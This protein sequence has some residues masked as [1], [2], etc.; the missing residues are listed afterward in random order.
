M[1][2]S[3]MPI[4][5]M[6]FFKS[7]RAVLLLLLVSQSVV[8]VDPYPVASQYCMLACQISLN[9]QLFVGNGKSSDIQRCGNT[10]CIESVALCAAKYCTPSE[11][12]TGSSFLDIV[13]EDSGEE[14]PLVA[15]VVTSLTPDQTVAPKILKAGAKKGT[16]NTT[17][18]PDGELFSLALETA[19]RRHA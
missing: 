16:Q 3:G 6:A 5:S 10:L 4:G 8:C 17:V 18:L 14:K 2:S 1:Y 19:V 11:I 7:Y 9:T 13:C 15:D 12:A